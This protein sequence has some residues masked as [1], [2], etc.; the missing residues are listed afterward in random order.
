MNKT[1]ELLILIGAAAATAVSA[2]PAHAQNYPAKSIRVIVPYA[3]GGGTD[4][5]TRVLAQK[6]TDSMGPQIG[7][8]NRGGANGIIGSEIVA[9]APP[10]G[11]LLLMTTNALATNPWLYKLPFDT[12]KDFAPVTMTSTACS[13]LAIHPSLPVKS[14]QDLIVLAKARPG[15]LT[16][17]ASGAG[18]PSHLCALWCPVRLRRSRQ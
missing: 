18:Q 3:P 14:V 9:K 13:L 7:I 1:N 17:A 15:Q 11:Y 2:V 10:D 5:V 4:I 16:M 8:E 12:E 6:M